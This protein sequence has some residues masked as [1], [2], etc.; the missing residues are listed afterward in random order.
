MLRSLGD[1]RRVQMAKPR[2]NLRVRKRNG[3][4]A[5]PLSYLPGGSPKPVWNSP[6]APPAGRERVVCGSLTLGAEFKYCFTHFEAEPPAPHLLEQKRAALARL[7][8]QPEAWQRQSAMVSL[9]N[10]IHALEQLA[11]DGEEPAVEAFSPGLGSF[12]GLSDGVSDGNQPGESEPPHPAPEPSGLSDGVSDGNPPG[13]SE[14]PQPAPEPSGLSDGV[15]DGD[16]PI[17]RELARQMRQ[18]VETGKSARGRA[19]SDEEMSQRLAKLQHRVVFLPLRFRQA[20]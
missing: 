3:M 7:E 15:S 14:P 4:F 2:K 8:A 1:K 17:S 11:G 13:E 10:E 18:E 12:S 5:E 9:S 20:E 16:P 19:L 6:M